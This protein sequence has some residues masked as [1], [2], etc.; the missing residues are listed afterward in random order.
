MQLDR[1]ATMCGGAVGQLPAREACVSRSARA[2]HG[3]IKPEVRDVIFLDK[4]SGIVT[5]IFGRRVP[6]QSA[7]YDHEAIP[8]DRGL[9]TV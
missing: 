8:G 7:D 1:P 3:C 5:L 9:H 4:K 2:A 6:A